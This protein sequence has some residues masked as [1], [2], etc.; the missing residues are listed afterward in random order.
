MGAPVHLIDCE[1]IMNTVAWHPS[2]YLLAYAGD[3]GRY[4][5]GAISVFGYQPVL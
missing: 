1:N 5:K 3:E 4:N 2:M